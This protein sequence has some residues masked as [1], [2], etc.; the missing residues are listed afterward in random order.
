MTIDHLEALALPEAHD[1]SLPADLEDFLDSLG[2]EEQT[3]C[4][5]NPDTTE[6]PF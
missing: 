6:V 1:T 5:G 3:D 4:Y 2:I